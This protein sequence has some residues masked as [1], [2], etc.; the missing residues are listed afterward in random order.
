MTYDEP[1][2][3]RR[4][5]VLD[6]RY[7][8]GMPVS[9]IDF[10]IGLTDDGDYALDRYMVVLITPEDAPM[11]A[12][13]PSP[14]EAVLHAVT[15]EEDLTLAELVDLDTGTPFTVLPEYGSQISDGRVVLTWTFD[16]T[17]NPPTTTPGDPA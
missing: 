11:F 2:Q 1:T 5:A 3:R 10:L 9:E 16:I 6:V 7:R 8:Y 17:P 13:F 12:T 4:S 14:E 15:D